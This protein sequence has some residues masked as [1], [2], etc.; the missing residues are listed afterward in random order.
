MKHG[1]A[2]KE[3]IDA[4]SVHATHEF[5]IVIPHFNTVCMAKVMKARVRSDELVIDPVAICV[6]GGALSHNSNEVFIHGACELSS[7]F[8]K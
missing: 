7:T 1:L 3:L 2:R 5:V 6:S 8:A 4:N